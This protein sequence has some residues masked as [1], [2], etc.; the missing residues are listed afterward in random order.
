MIEASGDL[1]YTVAS[2]P[3]GKVV[4]VEVIRQGLKLK[5]QYYPGS[6]EC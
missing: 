3:V 4:V 2:T 6:E 5:F 1:P